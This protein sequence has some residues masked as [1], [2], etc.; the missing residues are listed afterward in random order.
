MERKQITLRLP[1]DIYGL[2]KKE[3]E[4][5]GIS[6]NEIII[7]GIV[8]YLRICPIRLLSIRRG[9]GVAPGP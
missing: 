7:L 9:Y 2:I 8:D 3:A 1:D 5:R 4:R 6:V